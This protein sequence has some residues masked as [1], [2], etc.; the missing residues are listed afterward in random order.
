MFVN[1]EDRQKAVRAY[2]NV[3]STDFSEWTEEYHGKLYSR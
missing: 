1:W 2:V 3:S